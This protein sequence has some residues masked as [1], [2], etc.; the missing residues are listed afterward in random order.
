LPDR[1]GGA[2]MPDMHLVDMKVEK[3]EKGEFISPTLHTAIKIAME[4]G[5]QTLLFL[6]RRGYA[7]LTLCRSCGAR[8]ECPQCTAWLVEHKKSGRTFCHHCDYGGRSPN[9]C[10]TCDAED[11]LVPIGP[12]VERIAEEVESHYPDAKIMVLSSD[13]TDD[14]MALQDKL[15]AI[16]R[17]DVDIIIGTQMT[18]KGHHFPFLTCV[19]IVDADIGMRGGDLRAGERTWQLLHQVAG[20]AGREAL[21]DGRK[22]QVYIQT[23]MPENTVIESLADH[24]RDAFIAAEMEQRALAQMPPVNRLVG[25]ILSG[26]NEKTVEDIGRQLARTAPQ[27]ADFTVMG[28]AVPAFAMLRGKYRRRLLIQATRNI[29]LQK[30]IKKWLAN[31]DVPSSIRLTVD[32][33]PQSF[34]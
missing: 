24:D 32:I 21:T 9:K 14:G 34:L 10:P 13:T 33:D 27:S 22:G 31:T 4:A 19:G 20:R 12:G 6:N 2:L 7:P 16:Q 11:S 18:A 26:K 23:F 1:F 5:E 30:T 15:D 8:L 3:T 28:P 25:I 29:N 17:G